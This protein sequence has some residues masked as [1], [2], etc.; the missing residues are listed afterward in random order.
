MQMKQPAVSRPAENP[1]AV[2]HIKPLRRRPTPS[3][4]ARGYGGGARAKARPVCQYGLQEPGHL[5]RFGLRPSSIATGP[6]RS[7]SSDGEAVLPDGEA[8]SRGAKPPVAS[9]A[10][11]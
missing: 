5:R 1:F 7:A 4:W 2:A 3:P 11:N 6:R 8:V 9:F 10:C